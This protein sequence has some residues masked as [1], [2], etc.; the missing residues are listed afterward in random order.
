VLLEK[1]KVAYLVKEY[2]PFVDPS[3]ISWPF[4]HKPA[5]GLHPEPDES[6]PHPPPVSKFIPELMHAKTYG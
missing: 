3:E 2:L 4:S 6:N 1:T 5:T